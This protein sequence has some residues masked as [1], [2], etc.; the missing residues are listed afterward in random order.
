MPLGA[1]IQIYNSNGIELA[2]TNGPV[3]LFGGDVY[4][5]NTSLTLTPSISNQTTNTIGTS[6]AGVTAS[7]TNTL[8]T[9]STS[10]IS[11]TNSTIAANSTSASGYVTIKHG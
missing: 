3:N 5:V 9:S 6:V 11:S 10:T 4:T 1:Y 2:A 8:T 7:A